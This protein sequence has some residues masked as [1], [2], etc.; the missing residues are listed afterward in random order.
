MWIYWVINN[1]DTIKKNTQILID[2]S[3]KI[4][5]EVNTEKT[6]VPRQ[7]NAEKNHDIKIGNMSWKCGAV[8]IFGNDDNKSKPDSGGNEEEIEY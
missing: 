3:K 6:N 4:G 8:Q 5:L 7:E 2:A 1:I